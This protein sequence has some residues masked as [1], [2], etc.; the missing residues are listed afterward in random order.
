MIRRPPRSTLF[1]YTTLFRSKLG[2]TQPEAAERLG[3][4]RST[5]QYWEAEIRP[6]PLTVE[7]ACRQLLRRWKQHLESGHVR[8][9]VTLD[10]RMPESAHQESN[11]LI[12]LHR[13]SA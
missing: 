3:L 11:L 4:S 5:V 6:V 9:P 12:E 8:T 7:L 2:Y 10:P 1:P 13:Q